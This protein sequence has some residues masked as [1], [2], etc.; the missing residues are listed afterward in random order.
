MLGQAKAGHALIARFLA[1]VVTGAL[2]QIAPDYA[3][4]PC[5]TVN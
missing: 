4:L 1:A 2:S 5:S 3:R